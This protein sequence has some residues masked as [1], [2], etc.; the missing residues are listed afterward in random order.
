VPPRGRRGRCERGVAYD[1]SV[2]IPTKDRAGRAVRA[3]EVM[4]TQTRNPVRIV[5]V[6][7]SD[8]PLEAPAAL[9]DAAR[10][11]GVDLSVVHHPPSTS[12]QRNRGLELVES[13]IVFFLD[14]DVELP[15]HYAA[16][17]LDRWERAG[18][19]SLGGVVG[20]HHIEP[21]RGLT[22]LARRLLMLHL[23]ERDGDR[24]TVRPSRKIRYVLPRREVTV[25]AVGAAATSF[26]TDLARK[27]R[28]DE[29]F[30]GYALGEDL[31]MSM[32]LSADAPILQTP[33]VRYVHLED[34]D[35]GRRSSRRWYYRGRREAYFRLRHLDPGP[36]SLAAFALSVIGETAAAVADSVRERDPAHV[37]AFLGGLRGALTELRRERR[38][39]G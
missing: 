21:D 34:P 18:L 31:D 27:H 12:G 37:R 20:V 4:L 8:P 22:A 9:G 30:A 28:F 35:S 38:Q 33:S 32:R 3:V 26:R 6:D 1:Y 15:P 36:L 29:R 13:P 5:V 25:P 16:V 14:D 2:V 23:T 11:A 24:T 19:E 39:H 10:S 7:A 17:L